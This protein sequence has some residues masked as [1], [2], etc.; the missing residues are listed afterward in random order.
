[1]HVLGGVLTSKHKAPTLYSSLSL[2]IS[3]SRFLGIQR[4]HSRTSYHRPLHSQLRAS[5]NIDISWGVDWIQDFLA[6]F[7]QLNPR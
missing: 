4:M 6:V 5:K 7:A 3:A 1:M 2:E